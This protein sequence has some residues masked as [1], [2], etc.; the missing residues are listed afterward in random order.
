MKK[1]QK[2]KYNIKT[3]FNLN[4]LLIILIPVAL[5][6]VTAAKYV[7]ESSVEI[8]YEAKNFYF[9]SYV[10]SNNTDPR[11]YTYEIGNDTISFDLKNNIDD[12]RASEVDIEFVA[13]ITDIQGNTVQDKNGE[14]VNEQ[15]GTLYSSSIDSQEIEFKNLPSGNYLI[16]AKAVTPYEKTLTAT[17]VLTEKDEE[18]RYEVHDT[19]NSPIL[20]LTIITED[21]SGDL[22]IN[23]EK[24][25][26][27]DSTNSKFTSVDTGYEAGSEVVTFEANSEYTFQFFKEEPSLVYT[28]ENF[29]VERITV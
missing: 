19:V 2:N 9:E 8:I 7:K 20:Q 1:H 4:K 26:A 6:G 18:I 22:Q 5:I 14:I 23:W 21:Y 13:T 15:T 3:E 28:N 17:F 11:A 29:L 27:P 12:L 16:T 24:G 25:V 10:L